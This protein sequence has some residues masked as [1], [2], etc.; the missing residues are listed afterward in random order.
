MNSSY[1]AL[2]M[3]ALIIGGVSALAWFSNRAG[4][5][6]AKVS[7]A[8]DALSLAARFAASTQAM[9]QAEADKPASFD[10]L[11]KRLQAGNA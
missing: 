10:A 1:A 9:A 7:S 2:G 5:I 6:S 8:D 4:R 11:L 3:I